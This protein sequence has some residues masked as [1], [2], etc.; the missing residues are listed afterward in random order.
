MAK[1]Q[2]ARVF[3]SGENPSRLGKEKSL[4]VCLQGNCLA[5]RSGALNNFR[6]AIFRN[7]V[8]GHDGGELSFFRSGSSTCPKFFNSVGVGR[9]QNFFLVEVGVFHR[10]ENRGEDKVDTGTTE[11][12]GRGS[13]VDVKER[14]S[15][16]GLGHDFEVFPE[17]GVR[18]VEF[19]GSLAKGAAVVKKASPE[20]EGS[21]GRSD[22]VCGS[23]CVRAR[24]YELSADIMW[25][26]GQVYEVGGSSLCGS[27]WDR[28]ASNGDDHDGKQ[29]LFNDVVVENGER[30]VDVESERDVWIDLRDVRIIYLHGACTGG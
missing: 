18:G 25:S 22:G 10:D 4:V 13:L 19:D 28:L 20:V 12:V 23:A 15:K 16:N 6:V 7:P 24:D 1:S 3:V 8:G 30:L 21:V 9:N 2:L 14:I 29:E 26:G 17:L 27:I 5:R 11:E